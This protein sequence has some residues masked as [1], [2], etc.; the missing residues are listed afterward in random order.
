MA[1]V[2]QLNEIWVIKYLLIQISYTYIPFHFLG[3]ESRK[4]QDTGKKI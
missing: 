1:S 2:L 4:N 3:G